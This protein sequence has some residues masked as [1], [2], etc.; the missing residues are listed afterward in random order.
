MAGGMNR[1]DTD[2]VPLY[3][4]IRDTPTP[5]PE[6]VSTRPKPSRIRHCWVT[7][8]HGR[9]PGLLLEWRRTAAGW[10]GRVVRP[11]HEDTAWIVVEEWLLA[12]QLDPGDG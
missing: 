5:V 2:R 6:P 4:R 11:V 12:E 1:R 9:L 3:Q 10:Q 7:D 8:E